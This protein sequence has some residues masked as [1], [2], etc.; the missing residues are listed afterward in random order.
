[1]ATIDEVREISNKLRTNGLV[2]SR[3]PE[4]TRSQF[5]EFANGEFA[6]DYGCTLVYVFDCFKHYQQIINTQ[7]T[8]IDYIITMLKNQNINQPKSNGVKS[9]KFLG[10]N[11]KE[12]ENDL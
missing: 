4:P 11:E 9:P 12:K 3:L 2:I 1:M 7:D 5:I 6:G 10:K 8:K